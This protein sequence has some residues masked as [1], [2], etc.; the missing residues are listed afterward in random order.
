MKTSFINLCFSVFVIMVSQAGF[1]TNSDIEKIEFLTK[2]LKQLD[3]VEFDWKK[4]LEL[5]KENLVDY[6]ENPEGIKELYTKITLASDGSKTTVYKA[7]LEKDRPLQGL[8]RGDV[9]ALRI[10]GGLPKPLIKNMLYP[11]GCEALIRLSS[12][13]DKTEYFP[14]LYGIYFGGVLPESIVEGCYSSNMKRSGKI[15]NFRYEEMTWVD[16]TF[17][18]YINKENKKLG[19]SKLFE[20][21]YGEWVGEAFV[22]ISVNDQKYRN[23]GLK[24]VDYGRAYHLG[25]LTYYFSAGL[26]PVRLDFDGFNGC[27][28]KKRFFFFSFP[29]DEVESENGKKFVTA[30]KQREGDLFTLFERYFSE[31]QKDSTWIKEHDPK[32]KHFFLEKKWIDEEKGLPKDSRKND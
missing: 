27:D 20:F 19:M 4:V 2:S 25:D 15:C 12:L 8:K 21:L 26:M 32:A 30:W 16:T 23:F 11:Q 5:I 28:R 13:R 31:Y 6:T 10:A 3:P 29:T 24:N 7:I 22:G 1:A 18:S 14:D 9:I 17:E